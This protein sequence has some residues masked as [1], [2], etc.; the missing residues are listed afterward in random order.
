MT[1]GASTT[2]ETGRKI[3][4]DAK[5]E[6]L[7]AEQHEYVHYWLGEENCTYSEVVRLV[8]KTFGL[9]VSKSSVGVYY[10][11]QNR[12]HVR[13]GRRRGGRRTRRSAHRPLR[14]R[15]HQSRQGPRL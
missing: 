6:R 1:T 12:S 11:R 10:Q 5:L 9:Q 3:R 2:T 13:P 15:P 4:G 8:S 7:T 14:R